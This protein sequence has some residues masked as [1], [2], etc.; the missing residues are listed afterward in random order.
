[1]NYAEYPL[2]DRGY[3]APNA[4]LNPVADIWGLDNVKDEIFVHKGIT[5][6]PA[7]AVTCFDAPGGSKTLAVFDGPIADGGTEIGE[8]DLVA[9]L[10][11]DYG[12]PAGMYIDNSGL[13]R[14][15]AEV[16]NG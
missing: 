13:P 1:M 8:G 5:G 7:N 6:Y 15:Q 9:L 11:A 16:P 14:C 10:V 4:S 12:W 2:T 3:E